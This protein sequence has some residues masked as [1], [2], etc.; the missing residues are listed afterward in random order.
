M[1]INTVDRRQF[2]RF[3]TGSV[4]LATLYPTGALASAI[5]SNP[6]SKKNKVL[7][8]NNLHTGEKLQTQF[9]S[10]NKFIDSEL[11]KI[12]HIFRDFRQNEIHQIDTHLLSQLD[13]IQSLLNTDAE[14]QIISGYRS[15]LTNEQLRSNS[16]GVAKKSFHMLGQAM[17]FRL[18]G[19]PLDEVRDAAR[20][21][22]AGGVGYYPNS[23]FVHID[24]GPVRSW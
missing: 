4:A 22:K 1:P 11:N 3:A 5:E 12:Y 15:P 23:N 17:D 10:N 16:S 8:F 18:D 19:V 9:Y 24:S 20:I 2:L 21:L 14:V 7:A 6:I 13:S